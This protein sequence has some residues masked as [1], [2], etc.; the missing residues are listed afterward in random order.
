MEALIVPPCSLSHTIYSRTR[1]FSEGSPSSRCL[2]RRRDENEDIVVEEMSQ[3]QEDSQGSLIL[4]RY[5]RHP[6]MTRLVDL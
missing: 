2:K 4:A 5:P 3:T 6:S 1:T